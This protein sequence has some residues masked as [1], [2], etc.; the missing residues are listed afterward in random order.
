MISVQCTSP[1][2][3]KVFT[4]YYSPENYTQDSAEK[5]VEALGMVVLAS[6]R[7]VTK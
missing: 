7:K 2:G 6:S 5:A 1:R 4:L 3:G